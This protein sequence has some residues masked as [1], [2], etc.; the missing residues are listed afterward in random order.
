MPR[1]RWEGEWTRGHIAQESSS[2][3]AG[4]RQEELG[5]ISCGSRGHGAQERRIGGSPLIGHARLGAT[6]Y[7]GQRQGPRTRANAHFES[8]PLPGIHPGKVGLEQPTLP[9]EGETIA[10]LTVGRQGVEGKNGF[11]ALRF[12]HFLRFCCACIPNLEA[13]SLAR[14]YGEWNRSFICKRCGALGLHLIRKPSKS[15]HS[16]CLTLR[17]LAPSRSLSRGT[18]ACVLPRVCARNAR[19]R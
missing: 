7:R 8:G 5:R 17:P 6:L 11:K 4:T 13:Q 2:E 16:V 9:A 19:R 10:L 1:N 12:D 15:H 18:G 3:P 14:R